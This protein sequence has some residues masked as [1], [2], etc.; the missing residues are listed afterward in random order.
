MKLHNLEIPDGII[1]KAKELQAMS[2]ENWD[3]K[4]FENL[5]AVLGSYLSAAIVEQ[6]KEPE[7]VTG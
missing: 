2:G 1:E 6:L 3:T 7:I 5:T 4:K